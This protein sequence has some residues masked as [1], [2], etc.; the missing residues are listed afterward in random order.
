MNNV[1]PMIHLQ[2]QW[3]SP[4]KNYLHIIVI[5]WWISWKRIH[6]T[7]TVDGKVS[8]K[9]IAKTFASGKAEKLVYQTLKDCN[10]PYERVWM[11]IKLNPFLMNIKFHFIILQNDAINPEDLTFEKFY[12]IYKTLCPRTD[13]D[14]LF[15]K[16]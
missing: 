7:S 13:I 1:C 14:D 9:A 15:K 11:S 16:M 3:V 5:F 12:E 10:L 2:K 8:V 6:L 4:E